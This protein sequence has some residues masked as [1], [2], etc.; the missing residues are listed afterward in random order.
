MAVLQ[1]FGIVDQAVNDL[2]QINL[3]HCDDMNGQQ[4]IQGRINIQYENILMGRKEGKLW[5]ATFSEDELE[6]FS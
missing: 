2:V 6:M 3:G 5:Q 1:N 4:K